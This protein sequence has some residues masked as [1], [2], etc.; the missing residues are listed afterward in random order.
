VKR[1]IGD[2]DQLDEPVLDRHLRII[3]AHHHLYVRGNNRYL[4]DEYMLHVALGHDIRASVYVEGRWRW[5]ES[6][7]DVLRPLGEVEF[8]NDIAETSEFEKH[9][10]CRVAAAIVGYADLT[11]GG[12][13]AELL[14]AALEVSPRRFRGVRQITMWHPNPLFLRYLSQPPSPGLMAHPDFTAGMHELARRDLSFDAT[15]FHH[16]LPELAKLA[17]AC[18]EARIILC[19]LGLA[20]ADQA[21]PIARGR[22]FAQWRDNLAHLARHP[23][24]YCKIGGLG[25][26][27]WGFGFEE[28]QEPIGYLELAN[29]W[30]PYVQVAIELF[31]TARCMMASNFPN[32]G[33]TVGFVPLWNAY[34]HIARSYSPSEKRALFHDTAQKVYR[35]EL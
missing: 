18:P 7:P 31:G 13:V 30:A 24:V 6:G 25:T 33:R 23:N 17:A 8:A 28:R 16:Q 2:R 9:P 21:D 12:A 4:L 14:D 32:D 29:H 20:V 19:H 35:I 5:R 11:L 22:A 10:D 26:A 3:D 1:R 15:V 34:K 27:Y